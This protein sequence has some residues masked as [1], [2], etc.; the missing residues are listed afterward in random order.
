MKMH[1][2]EGK[3]NTIIPL[4]TKKKNQKQNPQKPDLK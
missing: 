2:E 4:S 1:C 3:K